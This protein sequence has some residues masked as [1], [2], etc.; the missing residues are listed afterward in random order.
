MCLKF[1]LDII[2]GM[3]GFLCYVDE[4]LIIVIL[5]VV[6]WGVCIFDMVELVENNVIFSLFGLVVLVFFILIFWLWKVSLWFC[7]WVD[8][9]NCIVFVGKFCLLSNVCMI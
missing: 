3:L 1:I 4:L 9:K 8:V 2:N 7:D 5:V 6:K